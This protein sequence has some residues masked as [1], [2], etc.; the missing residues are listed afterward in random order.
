MATIY[1]YESLAHPDHIRLLTLLPGRPESELHAHLACVPLSKTQIPVYEAVS[2]TWDSTVH[3]GHICIGS[4][5]QPMLT[6]TKNLEAALLRLRHK[7]KPRVLWIDAICVNQQDLVERSQ[8][9]KR[10]ADVY[11]LAVRVI[12]LVR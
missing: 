12:S 7:S 5:D 11:T 8:Q 6:I 9:V 4:C 10:M 2:Y 3:P 1:S